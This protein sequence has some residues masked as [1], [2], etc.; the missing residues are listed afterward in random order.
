MGCFTFRGDWSRAA[1]AAIFILAF[2]PAGCAGVPPS[3][4][5]PEQNTC[6]VDFAPDAPLERA[7]SEA[8][9]RWGAATGCAISLGAGGIPVELAA[10]L[11]R[12]DGSQSRGETSGDRSHVWIHERGADIP[13]TVLHEMGH[14]LGGDHVNSMGVLSYN[15]GYLA[16]IDDASLTEVCSALPCQAFRPEAP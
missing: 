15:K 3:A 11:P 5:P 1:R 14:A 2:A 16:V 8:A 7:V 10:S 9:T 4:A 13:R 12:D 6:R